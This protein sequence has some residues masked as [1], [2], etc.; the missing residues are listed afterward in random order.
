MRPIAAFG[1]SGYSVTVDEDAHTR[2]Y[3]LFFN[4]GVRSFTLRYTDESI[5]QSFPNMTWRQMAAKIIEIH[6]TRPG[7]LMGWDVEPWPD[8]EGIDGRVSPP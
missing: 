5:A 6:K 2:S 7:W 1:S 8:P 4:G 3:V